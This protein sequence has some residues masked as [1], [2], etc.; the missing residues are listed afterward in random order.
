M[1]SPEPAG[2]RPS[3][4]DDELFPFDSR[5]VELD[6]NVVHYIDEGAGPILLMLHGNPTWS[7][8]YRS[9]I[10]SLS[11][12]FRCIALDYPGFGL[13]AAAPGYRYR[14]DEHAAVVA[15][16]I[17]RLDL[18]QVTLLAH[19]WGGPIGLHA[20]EQRPDRFHRLVLTNTWAW[21]MNGD[22]RVEAASRLMGGLLGRQ[23][24]RRFNLFVN[25][26]IPIGH[27]RRK[28]SA[29]E[30][31]HYRA[32]LATPDRRQAC[33][34]MP[35]AILGSRAFLAEVENRLTVLAKLPVLIVWADAD[36]AFGGKELRRW[37]AT[38]PNHTTVVLPGVGHY[39]AS[40]APEQLSAAIRSWWAEPATGTNASDDGT[41]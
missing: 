30:M 22:L 36:V 38:F 35:G 34:V 41:D 37:E 28:V 23:L 24:I 16:F 33:A 11:D 3:W 14:P 1:P 7:F 32:A 29:A 9:L 26:F 4:V 39:V 40:D 19:D 25:A 5:F 21:P 6:G 15:A 10:G 13:S 17:D 31:A 8:E 27:R 12:R 20:A 2:V 18:S